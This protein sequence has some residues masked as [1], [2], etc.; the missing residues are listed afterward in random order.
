MNE[1]EICGASMA[2]DVMGTDYYCR[3]EK[4]HDGPHEAYG[5][6]RIGDAYYRVLWHYT[7]GNWNEDGEYTGPLP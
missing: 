4:G 3:K 6:A 5:Y 1:K 7:K 2:I